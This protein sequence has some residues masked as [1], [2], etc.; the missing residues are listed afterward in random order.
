M[1]ISY[2]PFYDSN[3]TI[4]RFTN[5]DYNL[6]ILE[7]G[8]DVNEI[9]DEYDVLYNS[10]PFL[11]DPEWPYPTDVHSVREMALADGFEVVADGNGDVMYW[12]I[13]VADARMTLLTYLNTM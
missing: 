11:S 13:C 6:E 7:S 10:L 9:Y 8:D 2:K 1:P 12:Y 4:A 3:C 5:G